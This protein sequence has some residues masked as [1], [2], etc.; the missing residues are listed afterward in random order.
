MWRSPY[1][2]ASP[3]ASKR[4]LAFAFCLSAAMIAAGSLVFFSFM[5]ENTAI[6][7]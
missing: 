1:T 5:M 3:Y 6:G 7:M 2:G 4:F